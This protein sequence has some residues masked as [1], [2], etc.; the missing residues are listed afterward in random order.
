MSRITP[1]VNTL[2]V[3]GFAAVCIFFWN[4]VCGQAAAA[5][6]ETPMRGVWVAT[7]LNLDYPAQATTAPAELKAE[8]DE[9]LDQVAR[10]GMNTVF[11][12]VRPAADAIYPS[13]LFPWSKYLTGG[14]NIAPAD[15]FDPLQY[16]ITA[17]HAR[18]IAL[19]AWIN[20]YRITKDGE[21]EYAALSADS[22]AK[23][24]PEWVVKYK[25]GN[26]Y[27]NPGLPAV[28]QLVVEGVQ[29]ILQNYAVDGI[30]LDDYFYPGPDF[31]DADTYARY[32]M[33]YASLADWRRDNVNKLISWLSVTVHETAANADFG[34]SPAGIWANKSSL[35]AG[36]DTNGYQTY[37]SAYADSRLWVKEGWVDYICPQ[38]YWYIGQPGADYS[39]VANWWADTV[40]GTGVKLYIGLADYKA[41]ST[42]NANPWYGIGAIAKEIALDRTIPEISGEVHFRY[43]LLVNNQALYNYYAQTD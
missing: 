38:I 7:V 25:D 23:L 17:A 27:F 20:P 13:H 14:Q 43:Q 34:V 22:P 19:Q 4:G 18:G 36:S 41:G 11:L 8:A 30:H 1:F 42:D 28:R 21:A 15:G 16:W 32:G 33:G 37:F 12:Q 9:I 29:E 31:N 3:L 26:Y 2:C 5:A 35:A 24:H 39:T 40:R 10:M 6:S